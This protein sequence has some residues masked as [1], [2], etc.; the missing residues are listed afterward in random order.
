MPSDINSKSLIINIQRFLKNLN[1]RR[2][3]KRSRLK[4]LITSIFMYHVIL[5]IILIFILIIK[6]FWVYGSG[7]YCSVCGRI[8]NQKFD[9]IPIEEAN[10]NWP[11]FKRE[12]FR[13]K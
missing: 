3:K 11:V 2:K 4:D 10:P 7:T 5:I 6:K 13:F 1:I 12:L 9:S 8:G